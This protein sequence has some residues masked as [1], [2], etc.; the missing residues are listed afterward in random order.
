M[1]PI[2][3]YATKD[4]VDSSLGRTG[5]SIDIMEYPRNA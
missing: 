3:L 5:R 1:T 4:G 2:A